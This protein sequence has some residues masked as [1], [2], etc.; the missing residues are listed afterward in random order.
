MALVVRA[1]SE[2]IDG[3][4]DPRLRRKQT[5]NERDRYSS[6]RARCRRRSGRPP[7][8]TTAPAVAKNVRT[9]GRH[10][11]PARPRGP[12]GRAGARRCPRRRRSHAG[13]RGARASSLL[14]RLDLGT[15]DPPARG[16]HPLSS[17]QDRPA[18]RFELPHGIQHPYPHHPLLPPL[19][20]HG[21]RPNAAA[22]GPSGD[23]E[24]GPPERDTLGKER[25]T[26][27]PAE[28]L[29]AG[30]GPQSVAGAWG[31]EA[32]RPR[33]GGSI[34]ARPAPPTRPAPSP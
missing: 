15:A 25:T 27:L 18:Q 1:L 17:P 12:S 21:N 22:I 26:P 24:T 14:E 13:R 28:I 31:T 20:R 9:V 29:A 16:E 11:R 19:P 5:L 23:G 6:P 2:E 7:A 4:D 34:A 32:D 30:R 3:D 8:L 33:V 10:R